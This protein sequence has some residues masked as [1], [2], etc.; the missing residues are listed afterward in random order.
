M[1]IVIDKVDLDD[2]KKK[3][4]TT[5]HDFRHAW[6]KWH[7]GHVKPSD[8]SL[9]FRTVLPPH[10][11]VNRSI[12]LNENVQS[13]E[14]TIGLRHNPCIVWRK[15]DLVDID[16]LVSSIMTLYHCH[17]MY[18]P[19]PVSCHNVTS[20]SLTSH[21]WHWALFHLPVTSG[22]IRSLFVFCLF[23]LFRPWYDN[24]KW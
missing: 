1:F 17:C 20:H 6:T 2:S 15:S 22:T 13:E 10:A 24:D 23:Q 5:D 4:K 19:S 12:L 21:L 16:W 9:T 18:H 14:Q 3:F 11:T 8:L 7:S